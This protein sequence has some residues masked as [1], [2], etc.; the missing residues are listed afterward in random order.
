MLRLIGRVPFPFNIPDWLDPLKGSENFFFSRNLTLAN[1]T[2]A[3][4]ISFA[5]A[6]IK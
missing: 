2:E 5:I 1:T 4:L 3:L 6:V